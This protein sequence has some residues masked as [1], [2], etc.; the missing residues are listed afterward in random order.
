VTFDAYQWETTVNFTTYVGDDGATLQLLGAFAG[1]VT[2]G[3]I[4]NSLQIYGMRF[5]AYR[6][7]D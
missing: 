4:P 3:S 6:I 5:A 2:I 1:Q 7:G